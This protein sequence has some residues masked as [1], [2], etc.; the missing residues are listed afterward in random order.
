[1][2][3][4]IRRNIDK[5]LGVAIVAACLTIGFAGLSAFTNAESWT[6]KEA[7]IAKLESN[8][9]LEALPH[10]NKRLPPVSGY[11]RYYAGST[12]NDEQVI[13]GELV[14]PLGAGYKPGIHIVANKKDF[15][16]IDDG[17]CAVINLVYSLKQQKIVSIQCNGF[18]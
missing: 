8:I 4:N 1:M 7:E 3:A 12:R 2:A 5:S 15:P 10:W 16:L 14:V 17:G 13:L 9:N 6:P 11:A 18:A